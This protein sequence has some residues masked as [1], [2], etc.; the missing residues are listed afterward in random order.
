MGANFDFRKYLSRVVKYLVYLI[1]ILTIIIGIFS[2]T[3][4]TGFSYSNLF[5]PGTG[6]QI[7]VFLVVVSIIYPFFGYATKK[8][9]LNKSYEQDKVKIKD[10]FERNNYKME[11]EGADFVKYRPKSH[12][13]RVMR[14][15]EDTI[16][17]S[18]SDNP[19]SLEGQRK[20]VY[21]IARMIEYA[22]RDDRNDD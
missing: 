5:R 4:D 11:C 15:F 1:I 22:I 14:M 13:L 8:V 12:F 7:A 20:D 21:R 17:L 16:T 6:F 9:Y 2:L 3:S 10:V 19:I 18:F